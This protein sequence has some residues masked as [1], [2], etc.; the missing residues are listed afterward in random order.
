MVGVGTSGVRSLYTTPLLVSVQHLSLARFYP[1]HANPLAF[2]DL[3]RGRIIAERFV[4]EEVKGLGKVG[5]R[6][7]H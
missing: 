6:L 5:A 4:S 2:V 3:R 1:P 7:Q